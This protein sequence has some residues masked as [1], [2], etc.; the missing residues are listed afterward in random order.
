LVDMY[1]FPFAALNMRKSK[2]IKAYWLPKI[3]YH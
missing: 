2:F 3:T 1:L